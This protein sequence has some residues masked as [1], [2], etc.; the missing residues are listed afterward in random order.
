[1]SRGAGAEG[2]ADEPRELRAWR[3]FCRRLEALG[4]RLA[5]GE[6]PDDPGDLTEGIAHLADQVS[7]WLGWSLAHADTKAPFFHRSNDLFTQ[8]GGPNPGQRL[9]PRPDRSARRYRV[10]AHMRSCERFALTL[11]VGFMHMPSGVRRRRSPRTTWASVRETPSRSCWAVTGASRAGSR[12]PRTSRRF[13]SGSSTSTGKRRSPRSSRSSVWTRRTRRRSGTRNSWPRS[14]REPGPRWSTRCSAG[15]ATSR[16]IGRGR[17]QHVHDAR[18][19]REGAPRCALRVLFWD[20]APDE[21]LVIETD[22]PDAPTGAC[23]SRPS[24][25]TSPSIPCTGSPR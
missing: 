9:S 2:P 18:R 14:S 5:A 6:F 1:M 16:S 4:E 8:W 24:V 12:F 21:A 10:A 17:R 23:S 15:T 19:G 22:V 20:L 11:R 3:D 7:C 13:R 25:G